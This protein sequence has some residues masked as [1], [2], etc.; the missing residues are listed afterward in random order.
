MVGL[1][2]TS[3]EGVGHKQAEAATRVFQSPPLL[4]SYKCTVK[5]DK[6]FKVIGMLTI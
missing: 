4:V 1:S 6:I 3:K 5:I 2:L